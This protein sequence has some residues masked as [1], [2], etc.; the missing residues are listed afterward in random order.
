M[1]G[2]DVSDT[3]WRDL[4]ED[5]RRAW[6]VAVAGMV[7]VDRK[8]RL[9]VAS[10][11]CPACGHRFGFR[12]SDQAIFAEAKGGFRDRV[13]QLVQASDRPSGFDWNGPLRFLVAC[14]CEQTHPGRPGAISHGCGASGWL[15]DWPEG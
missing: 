1:A 8:A 15:E 13:D 9:I 14:H 6:A 12:P 11:E 5:E 10:G 2:E 4:S 7:I 3:P